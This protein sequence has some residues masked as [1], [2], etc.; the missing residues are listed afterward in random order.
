MIK[1]ASSVSRGRN[2]YY[3]FPMQKKTFLRSPSY[4]QIHFT[5]YGFS[6]LTFTDVYNNIYYNNDFQFTRACQSSIEIVP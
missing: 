2:C 5:I 3:Y 6:F 4:I 1:R